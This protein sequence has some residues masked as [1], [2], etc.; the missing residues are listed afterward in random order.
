MDGGSP[1]DIFRKDGQ[2]QPLGYG[3]EREGGF[4]IDAD[5]LGGGGDDGSLHLVDGVDDDI[6]SPQENRRLKG[7]HLRLAAVPRVA[8]GVGVGVGDPHG[9]CLLAESHDPF[10]PV[11]AVQQVPL[12]DAVVQA[13]IQRGVADGRQTIQHDLRGVLRR[14]DTGGGNDLFHIRF[15]ML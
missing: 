8:G 5:K 11:V 10:P 9:V 15:L 6:A 14:E 4:P 2:I 3:E 7:T 13:Y 12:T 1:Q